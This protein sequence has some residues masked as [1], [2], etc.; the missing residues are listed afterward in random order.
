MVFSASILQRNR[1]ATRK[2]PR[3]PV[4]IEALASQKPATSRPPLRNRKSVVSRLCHAVFGRG[5]TS[6][7]NGE[8][9][10]T[11]YVTDADDD[12]SRSFEVTIPNAITISPE[13]SS[14]D[15]RTPRTTLLSPK[16]TASQRQSY[17]EALENASPTDRRKILC[18]AA[19][20]YIE[21]VRGQTITRPP[22]AGVDLRPGRPSAFF[23]LQHVSTAVELFQYDADRDF[24]PTPGPYHLESGVACLAA[25]AGLD[26]FALY[27]D[28]L[29]IDYLRQ[30]EMPFPWKRQDTDG[31]EATPRTVSSSID[32]I[33][34]IKR[35]ERYAKKRVNRQRPKSLKT[36]STSSRRMHKVP[37]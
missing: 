26:R 7:N 24:F 18:R 14:A 30:H 3:D 29:R 32:G 6:A 35:L 11:M 9:A 27:C 22:A 2:A 36:G 20:Q 1:T 15:G 8:R 12:R 5:I 23:T 19:K 31:V 10:A 34:D 28:L 25:C 17:Y 33:E 4:S 21:H 37:A 16:S 13:S